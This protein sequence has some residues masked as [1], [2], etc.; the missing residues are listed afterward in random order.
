MPQEVFTP[1]PGVVG[2]LRKQA[3]AGQTA[4]HW[5]RFL[6]PLEHQGGYYL[7]HNLTKQCFRTDEAL[8]TAASAGE[9]L[10]LAD[11]ER[12]LLTE[13]WFLLPEGKDEVALYEGV[14]RLLRMRTARRRLSSYTILP[15]TACNARCFYCVEN[16]TRIVTMSQ[17]TTEQTIDFILR[18]R[19][20]A[21]KTHLTWFG[22][23][24]LVAPQVID[25]VCA[26][27][28][29]AGVD[30]ESSMVT[31]G[32]LIDETTLAKMTGLWR[33]NRLQITLDGQEEDYNSRKAF[34]K[35]YPSAYRVL[36]ENLRRLSDTPI[37]VALRCNVD[38]DIVGG[39]RQMIDDLAL[40][41][42]RKGH[43][44]LYFEIL[45]SQKEREGHAALFRQC[46]EAR[47]YAREKG[48]PYFPRSSPHRLRVSVCMA[49]NPFGSTLISPEGLLYN[50]HLF[51]PGTETG[52]VRDGITQVDTLQTYAM[53][54]PVAERCRD[55]CF[56]P[57]CTSF[58]RCPI[59]KGQC[60]QVR[61][62]ELLCDL[63][64]ELE[65][66]SGTNETD[67]GN[68]GDLDPIC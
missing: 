38:E 50:C 63:R 31:N 16:G 62:A 34:L 44:G 32:I 3:F 11:P 10:N 59:T 54:E 14:L 26:A 9:S 12:K 37:R 43:F 65:R 67:F 40:T 66:E 56:L 53:P 45:F 8:Y 15:T 61:E 49:E 46:M 58:T 28:T 5:S 64:C 7:Y 39:L 27:L 48:F 1:D 23:E 2:I 35:S 22:G 68:D 19:D 33:V 6:V 51:L 4:L 20:P 36:L 57:N 47:L 29:E 17:E 21:H 30:F 24:P 52:N 13:C 60:R 25:R 55:C 41:I 42:P 18:T